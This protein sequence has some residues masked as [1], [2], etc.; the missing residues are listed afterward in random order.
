M[1]L[2]QKKCK[3]KRIIDPEEVSNFKVYDK[4]GKKHVKDFDEDY[5]GEDLDI[6]SAELD[7]EE[8]VIAGEDE[9]N[10]YYSLG[11]DDHIDL[12]ENLGN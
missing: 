3:K 8:E 4:P 5:P 12:E 11:G 7:V 1:W 9:E 2:R 10:D 6:P